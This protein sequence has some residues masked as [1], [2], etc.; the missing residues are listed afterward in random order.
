MARGRPLRCVKV[1]KPARN[2][3]VSRAGRSPK[4]RP[5]PPPCQLKPADRRRPAPSRI[6]RPGVLLPS[7]AKAGPAGTC[8]NTQWV[9]RPISKNRH[10]HGFGITNELRQRRG[11][12]GLQSRKLA[13]RA[14]SPTCGPARPQQNLLVREG[15]HLVVFRL[16][17]VS[18]AQSKVVNRL[19]REGE[20]TRASRSATWCSL[21]HH[22]EIQN[23]KPAPWPPGIFSP[24]RNCSYRACGC[25]PGL[26][27]PSFFSF[28]PA[29]ASLFRRRWV[30]RP[31]NP[32]HSRRADLKRR[33]QIGGCSRQI[34]QK[35]R[36]ADKAGGNGGFPAAYP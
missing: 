5:P 18:D 2:Y 15:N 22:M 8:P 9:I 25:L 31:P 1:A 11:S 17:P 6:F 7:A 33:Q 20:V 23:R 21:T 34:R 29:P 32:E 24:R 16:R 36:R 35:T 12:N 10:L 4:P 3:G 30:C 13:P 26:S 14:S 28:F 19:G 27:A